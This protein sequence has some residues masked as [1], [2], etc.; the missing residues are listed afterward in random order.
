MFDQFSISNEKEKID[1]NFPTGGGE[2]QT[3]TNREEQ[4]GEGRGGVSRC[5]IPD[6]PV[7][8]E[9]AVVSA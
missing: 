7:K 8:H 9:A 4:G 1:K 6:Y 2:R 5:Q 3:W